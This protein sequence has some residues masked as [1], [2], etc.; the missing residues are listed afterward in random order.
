MSKLYGRRWRRA[1]LQFLHEHPLCVMCQQAGRI[2]AATVVDHITPHRE[3]ETLFWD[4]ENW[5]AL[6]T[7]H[8]NATKQSME[9][10]GKAE[11]CNDF[12]EPLN[13]NDRW[14]HKNI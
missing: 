1:R 5:Q 3:D 4:R 14:F 8:H 11:G 13:I 9:K 12:G 7:T 10:G 6:C 2:A